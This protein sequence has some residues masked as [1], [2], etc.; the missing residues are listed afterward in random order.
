MLN[1]M[2]CLQT[3]LVPEATGAVNMTCDQL[4]DTAFDTHAG[5]YLKNGLC[6]LPPS[7][8][9]AIVE[10]VNFETL[11]QSWDAFKETVEAAAGCMEF[12][13]FLLYG[14]L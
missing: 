3:A 12:Y 13:T 2:H 7:D 14:Q 11:F 4:K 8:W 10:I 9:I 6:K 1:T 5:C